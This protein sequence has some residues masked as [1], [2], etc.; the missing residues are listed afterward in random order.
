MAGWVFVFLVFIMGST[1]LL[2]R[3]KRKVK[4]LKMELYNV[5]YMRGGGNGVNDQFDNPLYAGNDG[6]HVQKLPPQM[7]NAASSQLPLTGYPS[8]CKN[9]LEKAKLF[10]SAHTGP[11][12]A[13][14]D[15][16]IGSSLTSATLFRKQPQQ[17]KSL[18][19]K[20]A[21]FD[22]PDNESHDATKSADRANPNI[23]T[24][25][26]EIKSVFTNKEPVYDEIAFKHDVDTFKPPTGT[27]ITRPSKVLYDSDDSITETINRQAISSE[28]KDMEV[29]Q[30]HITQQIPM[31]YDLPRSAPR[32][33]ENPI[34][35][36]NHYETLSTASTYQADQKE[37]I[38]GRKLNQ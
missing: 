21:E 35:L 31:H 5:I 1:F 19:A 12:S 10:N 17:P 14:L 28:M 23:Y 33:I 4:Q 3:Y 2:Y 25:I 30:N 6:L 24:S 7:L 29:G 38:G 26:E 27:L 11:S 15:A 9:N 13:G 16:A 22:T 18:D 20:L 36:F 37:T 32:L 34:D 8:Y